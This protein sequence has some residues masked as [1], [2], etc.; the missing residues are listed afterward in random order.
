VIETEKAED[1][2][3]VLEVVKKGYRLNDKII[4]PAQVRVG[5]V[6]D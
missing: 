6:K 5:Q 1:E 4:R 2:N 3:R